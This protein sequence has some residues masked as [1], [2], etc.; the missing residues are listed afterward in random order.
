VAAA[1]IG[2]NDG[3]AVGLTVFARWAAVALLGVAVCRDVAVPVTATVTAVP[4]RTAVTAA[5]AGSH[6]RRV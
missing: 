4:A 6:Q 3:A 2:G 5:A 1:E